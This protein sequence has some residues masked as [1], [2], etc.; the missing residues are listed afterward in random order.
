MKF[1]PISMN[2]DA[3]SHQEAASRIA[4]IDEHTGPM[5]RCTD[6]HMHSAGLAAPSTKRFGSV[7]FLAIGMRL[8]TG[9]I[10]A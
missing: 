8:E 9:E 1:G 2:M 3:C 10:T 4:W 7:A 6:F 5:G